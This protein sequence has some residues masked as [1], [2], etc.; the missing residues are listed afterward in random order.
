MLEPLT[1]IVD[2]ALLALFLVGVLGG[3]H[4]VGM[5]GGVIG[6]L[7]SG[8][9]LRPAAT[10]PLHFS[11]NLGRIVT[12]SALGAV[13]GSVGSATLLFKQWLPVQLVLYL[14]ANGLLVALGLYLMGITRVLQPL[15]NA[16]H[17]VWRLVQPPA[18]RLLPIRDWKTAFPVGLAWGLLPCG[19]TYS[20]LST[21][22]VSGSGGRGA[23]M[24]LAFGLGT[25]PNMLLAGM[26][27]VQLR[28]ITRQR[29]VRLASGL[30]VLAFG[31][32]GLLHAQTL[33]GQIWQGVMCNT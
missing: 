18:A 28:R 11:Y 32:H 24:M 12:Y 33:G 23:E 1:Q 13:V 9:S 29:W 7:S 16:G 4:C 26:A 20:V 17:R 6:A 14:I 10:W 31:I 25:L 19:L 21:A 8:V 2:P 15:E 22:L 30:L 3:V 27:L 5:C